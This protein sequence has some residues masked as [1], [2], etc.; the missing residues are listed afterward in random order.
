MARP[1]V[2]FRSRGRSGARGPGI[3]AASHSTRLSLKVRQP[4]IMVVIID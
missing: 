3:L 2:L 1:P 4:E